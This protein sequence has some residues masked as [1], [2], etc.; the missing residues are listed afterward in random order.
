MRTWS[1]WFRM[2]WVIGI[3]VILSEN[4]TKQFHIETTRWWLIAYFHMLYLENK[5]RDSYVGC[6][7]VSWMDWKV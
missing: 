6:R 2:H 5:F 7:V 1:Q 3:S 4:E